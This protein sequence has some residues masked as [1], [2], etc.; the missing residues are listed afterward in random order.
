MR[1]KK[2]TLAKSR[3]DAWMDAYAVCLLYSAYS[4]S[5]D[6]AKYSRNIPHSR[7]MGCEE[8]RLPPQSILLTEVRWGQSSLS[9]IPLFF[10]AS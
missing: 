6:K 9:V 3:M 4:E 5:L 10:V 7:K 2:K 1:W 8:L